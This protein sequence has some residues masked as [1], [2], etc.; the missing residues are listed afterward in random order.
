V[1]MPTE[2]PICNVMDDERRYTSPPLRGGGRDRAALPGGR[3]KL[4]DVVEAIM[5]KALAVTSSERWIPCFVADG[6]PEK[7]TGC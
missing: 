3:Y 6:T 5:V 7:G 2:T 1:R 4:R